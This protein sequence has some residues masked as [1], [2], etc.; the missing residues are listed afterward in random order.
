VE[1][2]PAIKKKEILPFVTISMNLIDIILSEVSQ[3]EKGKYCMISLWNLKK[4]K[5]KKQ[6]KMVVA[7]G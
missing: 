2:Y 1:Y 3:T 5:T 7:N 6:N 4:L